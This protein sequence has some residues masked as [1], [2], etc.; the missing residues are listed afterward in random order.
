MGADLGVRPVGLDARGAAFSP[1][2][3]AP[4]TKNT[5]QFSWM[6]RSQKASR[7]SR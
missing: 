1:T 6:A 7:Q 5:F 4:P 3:G 2:P